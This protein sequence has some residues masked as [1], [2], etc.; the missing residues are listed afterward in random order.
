MT[1]S[2]KKLFKPPTPFTTRMA[3]IDD[4]HILVEVGRKTFLDTFA[5]FNTEEDMKIYI[6]KN[7]TVDQARKEI[8]DPA[9]SFILAEDGNVVIG[10]AKLRE[11]NNPRELNSTNGIEIERIYVVKNYLGK[12]VGKT[13]MQTCLEVARKRGYQV[14]WLGVWE[15]NPRAIAFYEKWGFERFGAHPFLLGNDSQTD[16]MMKML[17]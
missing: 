1:S 16:L 6:E 8:S 9:S 3:T 15:H 17:L 13:L 12:N 5:E 7:F 14:V 11:G 10:Y 4:V 2:T